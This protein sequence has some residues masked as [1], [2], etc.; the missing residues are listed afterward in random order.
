M[1]W[2]MSNINRNNLLI[3][4]LNN[5]GGEKKGKYFWTLSA[6]IQ[7]KHFCILLKAKT[8]SHSSVI[9]LV[10]RVLICL[11]QPFSVHLVV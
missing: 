4:M 11:L 2:L 8:F 6:E 10:S 9:G 3:L 5:C 7:R 1:L